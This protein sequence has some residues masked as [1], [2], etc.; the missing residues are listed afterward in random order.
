MSKKTLWRTAPLFRVVIEEVLS[1]PDGILES[2]LIEILK[3]RYDMDISKPELYQALIKL[4]L[5]G[6]IRVEH[7]GKEM[8]IRPSKTM[9]NQLLGASQ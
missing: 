2:E 9:M 5:N 6:F 4:E 3:K 1:K 8:K 7:I